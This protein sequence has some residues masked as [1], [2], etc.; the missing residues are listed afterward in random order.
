MFM[1]D[2]SASDMNRAVHKQ[3]LSGKELNVTNEDMRY[4]MEWRQEKDWAKPLWLTLWMAHNLK[5]GNRYEF[6]WAVQTSCSVRA[7]CPSM[8]LNSMPPFLCLHGYMLLPILHIQKR[9]AV[10]TAPNIHVIFGPQAKTLKCKHERKADFQHHRM[11]HTSTAQ[12]RNLAIC[13]ATPSVQNTDRY[14]L[15][16]SLV[17]NLMKVSLVLS[18]LHAPRHVITHKTHWGCSTQPI[19]CT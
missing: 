18:H 6:L 5:N 12:K 16:E 3:L 14:A 8:P 2:R 17:G 15:K 19:L 7:T 11:N 9:T 1:L 13:A 10:S 4:F